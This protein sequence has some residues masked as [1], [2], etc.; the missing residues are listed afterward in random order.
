MRKI[1]CMW[2]EF[3]CFNLQSLEDPLTYSALIPWGIAET[4]VPDMRCFFFFLSVLT[5]A[6]SRI[7]NNGG[8]GDTKSKYRSHNNRRRSILM[9]TEY[10]AN[11]PRGTKMV[12]VMLER[13]TSSYASSSSSLA[14][15]AELPFLTS[16]LNFFCTAPTG[17]FFP[18]LVSRPSAIIRHLSCSS[19]SSTSF[20]ASKSFAHYYT[21]CQ[22]WTSVL[23]RKDNLCSSPPGKGSVTLTSLGVKVTKLALRRA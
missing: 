1:R 3:F 7:R 20:L 17:N 4:A 11:G 16:S 8:R 12:S 19:L 2:K 21:I 13:A 9:T 18:V 15:I 14:T 10:T 6:H 23:V 22:F 5:E